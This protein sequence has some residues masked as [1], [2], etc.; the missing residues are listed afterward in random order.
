MYAGHFSSV[1]LRITLQKGEYMKLCPTPVDAPRRELSV[2]S[3]DFAVALLVLRQINFVRLHR[4]SNPTVYSWIAHYLQVGT[5]LGQR[6]N[7]VRFQI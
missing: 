6:H 7:L 3:L 1:F 5:S 4:M 2:H